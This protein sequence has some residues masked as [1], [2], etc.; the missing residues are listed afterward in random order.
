MHVYFLKKCKFSIFNSISL[1]FLLFIKIAYD[2]LFDYFVISRQNA[3]IFVL[4]SNSNAFSLNIFYE[5][6]TSN[7]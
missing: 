1:I 6:I 2:L 4:K 3:L 5:C 7:I